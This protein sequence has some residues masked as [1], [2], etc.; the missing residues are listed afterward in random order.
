MRAEL[1]SIEVEDEQLCLHGCA[2]LLLNICIF[3]NT[4][5][6]KK[7]KKQLINRKKKKV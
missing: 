2:L 4:F 1:I 5:L 7:G 6:K 3:E